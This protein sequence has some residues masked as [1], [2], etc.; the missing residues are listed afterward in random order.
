MKKGHIQVFKNPKERFELGGV[1]LVSSK[2]TFSAFRCQG[3]VQGP[4]LPSLPP[5]QVLHEYYLGQPGLFLQ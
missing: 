2:G 5:G 4:T 1:G 3:P